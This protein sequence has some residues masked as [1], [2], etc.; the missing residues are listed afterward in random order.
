MFSFG[1]GH[2]IRIWIVR[3]RRKRARPGWR[4]AAHCAGPSGFGEG[5]GSCIMGVSAGLDCLMSLV[6]VAACVDFE[7]RRGDG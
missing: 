4:L 2:T 1:G 3:R 7:R 6:M 5:A